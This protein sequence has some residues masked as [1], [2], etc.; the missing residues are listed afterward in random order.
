MLQ[1]KKAVCGKR[2]VCDHMVTVCIKAVVSPHRKS[3][4]RFFANIMVFYSSNFL[5]CEFAGNN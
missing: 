4:F 1:R 5:V 3:A 2:K